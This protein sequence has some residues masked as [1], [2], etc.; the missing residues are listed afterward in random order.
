MKKLLPYMSIIA[1]VLCIANLIYLSMI[2]S[3]LNDVSDDIQSLKSSVYN[4]TKRPQLGDEI[5]IEDPLYPS[6]NNLQ[7]ILNRIEKAEK[8]IRAEIY[9]R[10]R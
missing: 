4:I 1:I 5:I 10:S 7:D 8:N 3:K 6:P 2:Q 9:Y